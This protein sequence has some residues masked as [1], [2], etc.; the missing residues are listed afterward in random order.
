ML[1]L[2]LYDDSSLQKIVKRSANI[3]AIDIDNKGAIE[4]AKR[5]RG[6]P[7]IANRLLKKGTRLCPGYGRW[8]NYLGCSKKRSR[9]A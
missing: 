8:D 6:T 2:D 3:L 5:S 9:N 1:N 7:R 4:I